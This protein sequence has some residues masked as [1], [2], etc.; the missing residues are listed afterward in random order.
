MQEEGLCHVRGGEDCWRTLAAGVQ[1]P[2]A[3]G[4]TNVCVR[5]C[6]RVDLE[7]GGRAHACECLYVLIHLLNVCVRASVRAEIYASGCG[8][9][10]AFLSTI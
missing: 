5:V 10:C 7:E 8:S 1:R 9:S 4:G 2:L 6:V 3:R